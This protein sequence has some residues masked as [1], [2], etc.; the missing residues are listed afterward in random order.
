[1]NEL[2]IEKRLDK[3]D[4]QLDDIQQ[5]ML[6]NALQQKDIDSLKEEVKELKE[7]QKELKSNIAELKLRPTKAKADKWAIIEK[8]IFHGI[9]TFLAACVIYI[10]KTG[11]TGN[12]ID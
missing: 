3:I 5:L 12:V 11:A 7:E 6:N 4:S 9:L 10:I 1:M 2:D 8:G